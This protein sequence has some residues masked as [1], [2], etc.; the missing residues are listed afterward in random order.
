[1]GG[2][3]NGWGGVFGKL[4]R[5]ISIATLICLRHRWQFS[6]FILIKKILI[7]IV[8]RNLYRYRKKTSLLVRTC[9]LQEFHETRMISDKVSDGVSGVASG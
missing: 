1:M 9:F 3:V 5:N 8:L 7:L 2:I 6:W 4:L